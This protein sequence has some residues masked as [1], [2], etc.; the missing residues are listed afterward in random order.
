MTGIL[1]FESWSVAPREVLLNG[2]PPSSHINAAPCG[3][4]TF[5]CANMSV[6]I[7]QRSMCNGYNDCPRGE[8]EDI[9]T[10]EVSQLEFRLMLLSGPACPGEGQCVRVRTSASNVHRSRYSVICISGFPQN[11]TCRNVTWLSCKNL[12]LSQVP[13]TVTRNVTRISGLH[14][15]ILSVSGT[16]EKKDDSP[17]HL[18]SPPRVIPD[19]AKLHM[20]NQAKL[21]LG[22]LVTTCCQLCQMGRCKN[23]QLKTLHLKSGFKDLTN[24]SWLILSDNNLTMRGETF[25]KLLKLNEIYFKKFLYCTYAPLVPK[26]KPTTDGVSSFEHLLVKPVLRVTVWI[27]A[28]MIGVGNSL[29]LWGRFSSKDENRVLSLVIRNLAVSDMLMSVYL[30]VIGFQDAQLRG[31]YNRQAHIW[32]SSWTCTCIGIVAMISSEEVYPH[33]RGGRVE[34]HLRKTTLNTPDRDSNLDIP[35]IGSPV[36]C[37]SNNL[38]HAATKRPHC[39]WSRVNVGAVKTLDVHSGRHLRSLRRNWSHNK[40]WTCT[41]IVSCGR[42]E[43]TGNI[44]NDGNQSSRSSQTRVTLSE[45]YH[46]NCRVSVFILVFMSMERFL[47][48]A[49]PFGTHQTMTSKTA[50]SWLSFIWVVGFSLAAVPGE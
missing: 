50:V 46:K 17:Y 21:G 7:P 45:F 30:V 22:F 40:R 4:G 49:I 43:G 18:I 44:I 42:L 48:I 27:V 39:S 29:V 32:M 14:P 9:I 5:P 26:C 8:D 31:V 25:P 3:P 6:C 16:P 38:N 2:F 24:L 33:L 20:C 37:E 1:R 35:V 41:L 13:Q 36:Y 34:S 23:N 11:C 10:C 19:S 12:G 47:L 28:A 15:P